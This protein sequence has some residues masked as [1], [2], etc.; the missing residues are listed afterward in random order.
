MGAPNERSPLRVARSGGSMSAGA[1]RGRCAFVIKAR[2]GI[3]VNR[4]V[5]SVAC[6]EAVGTNVA[7]DP[8][9][10]GPPISRSLS[11]KRT[12]HEPEPQPE[13]VFPVRSRNSG[14]KTGTRHGLGLG[15]RLGLEGIFLRQAPRRELRALVQQQIAFSVT[16]TFTFLACIGV[17]H[18]MSRAFKAGARSRR[19]SHDPF[20]RRSSAARNATRALARRL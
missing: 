1:L 5:A 16:R 18:R 10:A 13:P 9:D 4:T 20:S 6:S 11:E 17:P 3:L 8:I 12:N 15:L 7:P 2:G 19:S 14:Q